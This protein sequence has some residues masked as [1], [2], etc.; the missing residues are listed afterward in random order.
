MGNSSSS[1]SDS[2][3]YTTHSGPVYWEDSYLKTTQR[4]NLIIRGRKTTGTF[5]ICVHHFLAMKVDG[6]WRVFERLETGVTCFAT[7]SLNG[8]ECQSL[9]CKSVKQVWDAA[10]SVY[11]GS[12]NI[13]SNNCNHWTER[14]LRELGYNITLSAIC[15]CQ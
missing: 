3:T 14:V 2:T 10:E 12:Y 9:G 13:T 4:G 7:T 11:C 15:S 6:L 8:C 5:G 1:P